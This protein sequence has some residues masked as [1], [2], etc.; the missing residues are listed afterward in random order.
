M[1][2]TISTNKLKVKN[3]NNQYISMDAISDDTTADRVAQ[4]NA[5]GVS[6]IADVEAH[7]DEL[8]ATAGNTYTVSISGNSLIFN[9]PAS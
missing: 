4:I 8:I 9:T 2:I 5:A 6:A 3:D 7:R 1:P